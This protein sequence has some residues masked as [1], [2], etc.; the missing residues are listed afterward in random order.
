M[1]TQSK[2]FFKC[3]GRR[4]LLYSI[5]FHVLPC[6]RFNLN[7]D[8]VPSIKGRLAL[9]E[10]SVLDVVNLSARIHDAYL[11]WNSVKPI[12]TGAAFNRAIMDR[13]HVTNEGFEHRWSSC[14]AKHPQSGVELVCVCAEGVGCYCSAHL[15]C[16]STMDDNIS[17]R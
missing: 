13:P 3:Q 16:N 10:A 5:I 15:V 14:S 9:K 12:D 8:R 2:A 6:A 1:P 7:Q 17:F 11:L 4:P